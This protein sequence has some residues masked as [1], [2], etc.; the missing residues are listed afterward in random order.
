[1]E[2]SRPLTPETAEVLDIIRETHNIK[3]L[4]VAFED[5][6]LMQSFSFLPGQ[7]GQL[8]I[9]GA[10]ESTFAIASPPSEREYLQ[11]SVM[12][13][14]V[15]TTAI[16]ELSV[17]DRVTV[18]APM[19]NHF[20]VDLWKGKSILVIGGGI[21]MAPLRSLFLHLLDHRE[22]YADLQLIY[23][24]RTPRD[25]CYLDDCRDW[26]QGSG[27]DFITTIDTGHPDWEGRVGLVPAVLEE[28][29]PS[30]ENNIAVTCGPP[31]MIR[32]VLESLEK[33]GFSPGQI[34]TTLERRMKCGIGL[35]G[36]CN[37]G[38]EYVCVDGPVFSMAELEG[39]P[40]E[41]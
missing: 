35:C 37:V 18:R 3:S 19:G 36:R 9:P 33:M 32:Y 30:P 12:K 38:P 41:M 16:H 34:Y 27:V 20:P 29:G 15:V 6:E 25:I 4:R 1:M 13:T 11:F 10:G 40:D 23:G 22:D 31:V 17:G 5:R 28:E 26:E 21:G 8:G 39:L 2:A 7:T 14:G 24:A